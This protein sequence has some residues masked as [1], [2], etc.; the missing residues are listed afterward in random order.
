MAQVLEK[1]HQTNMN[2]GKK[3]RH[4]LTTRKEYLKKEIQTSEKW[5]NRLQYKVKDFITTHNR[6]GS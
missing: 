1:L 3:E 6:Q 4:H 2:T 5:I